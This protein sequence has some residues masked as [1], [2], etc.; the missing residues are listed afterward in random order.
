MSV[1]TRVAPSPTGDP[2]LGTAYMALFNYVFAKKNGGQFILRIEDTDRKRSSSAAER[3]IYEALRWLGMD[4]SEGPDKGGDYGPYRQSERLEIYNQYVNQLIDQGDAFHCFCTQERLDLLRQ[5]QRKAQQTT[6]YD[7]LCSELDKD[8]VQ[9]RIDAGDPC[10]VRLRVPDEGESVFSDGIR[11]EIRIPWSQVD[12]QVLLKSD[13][14]PTYHLAVVVD[15]HLMQIS[16]VLRGEEWINS[17][18]KHQLL[19]RYFGWEMPIHYHLPLLRNP[20]QSKMSK[21]KNPTSINYYRDSGYLPE[22]LINYLSLMGWSMPDEREIFKF[23]EFVDSFDTKRFSV[24][25]PI[26]DPEKLN[27]MNGQYIR[28]LDENAF[29]ERVKNWIFNEEKLRLLVPLVID[30][31]ER[32]ADLIPQVDY[33]LGERQ[34]I[35]GTSF[36]H[37]S[38]SL[39]ESKRILSHIIRRLEYQSDWSKDEL[40]TALKALSDT[41]HLKFRDFLFPLFVSISGKSVSLPL[42]DSMSFL[43]AE[44][45]RSRVQSGIEALGGNSKKETRRLDKEFAKLQESI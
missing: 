39:E 8:E 32:L 22:A 25:G 40:Y 1:R 28:D 42:F 13:G 35:D 11:G 43:G 4:W 12:M 14:F 37:K 9:R 33:L 20:D 34:P 29:I 10:V 18:P 5:T 24:R 36:A 26:F 44:L 41:M 31:T 6:R 21:R 27:W 16:H 30:R 2:H 7:G 17:L 23:S 19:Y 15:D 45:T 38:L 3:K